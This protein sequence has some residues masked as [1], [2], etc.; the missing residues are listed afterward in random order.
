[1]TRV[2]SFMLVVLLISGC[3]SSISGTPAPGSTRPTPS[4]P[5]PSS[6]TAVSPSSSNSG[7]SEGNLPIADKDLPGLGF[8]HVRDS[9]WRAKL[10]DIEVVQAPDGYT[11]EVRATDGSLVCSKMMYYNWTKVNVGAAQILYYHIK[12]RLRKPGTHDYPLPDYAAR[13]TCTSK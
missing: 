5:S 1:M 7:E 3:G 13:I 10:G 11:S 8:V 12:N 6:S 2:V 4:D 9:V